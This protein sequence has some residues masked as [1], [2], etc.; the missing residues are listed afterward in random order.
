MAICL[1]DQTP[2]RRGR[3]GARSRG[4]ARLPAQPSM[5]QAEIEPAQVKRDEVVAVIAEMSGIP[6]TRLVEQ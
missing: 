2:A 6:V 3:D 1:R 5:S 4:G